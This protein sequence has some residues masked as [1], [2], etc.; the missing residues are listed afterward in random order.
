MNDI[1]PAK[2]IYTLQRLLQTATLQEVIPME[3]WIVIF[4]GAFNPVTCAHLY[5]AKQALMLDRVEQ[6]LFLPVGDY[7]HKHELIPARHRVAMLEQACVSDPGFG[8][9]ALEAESDYPL[10]TYDSLKIIAGQNPNRGV[11]F[12]MGSDNLRDLP[13]WSKCDSLL[14]EFEFIVAPRDGDDPERII[15]ETALLKQHKD[16]FT[17]I[18]WISNIRSTQ[19]RRIFE[20]G[21]SNSWSVPD[22]VNQ[23]IQR[24]HLF[25]AC[26]IK[27]VLD[28]TAKGAK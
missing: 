20:A 4:G 15:E 19:V 9:S 13:N 24:H 22:E 25:G 7:Y 23:Y 12:L 6:V 14:K 26:D 11:A 8:V 18:D 10:R 5:M 17:I 16:R 21:G 1:L 2:M 27:P 28:H 3:K